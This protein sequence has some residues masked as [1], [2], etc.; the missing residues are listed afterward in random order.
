LLKRILT[1]I[2]I[3]IFTGLVVYCTRSTILSGFIKETKYEFVPLASAF[4]CSLLVA[5]LIGKG[6]I[7]KPLFFICGFF[8]CI[9]SFYWTLFIHFVIA[10]SHF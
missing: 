1:V 4:I 9:S 6:L 7:E 10:F 5:I 2:G 8:I 3:N